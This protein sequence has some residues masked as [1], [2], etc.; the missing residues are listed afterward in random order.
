MAPHI[1]GRTKPTKTKKQD[2][3]QKRKRGDVDAEKLE[4]AVQELVSS[5]VLFDKTIYYIIPI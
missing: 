1:T 5:F 2:R 3:A 4:Q